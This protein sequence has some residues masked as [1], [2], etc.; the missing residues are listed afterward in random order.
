MYLGAQHIEEFHSS[1]VKV[2]LRS[3]KPNILF[4]CR[5]VSVVFHGVR[6]RMQELKR[7]RKIPRA[8]LRSL[9]PR[10]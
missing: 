10:G 3:T 5:G 2:L 9:L 6:E 8:M 4:F 7:E 1:T